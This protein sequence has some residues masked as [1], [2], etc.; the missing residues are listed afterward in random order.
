MNENKWNNHSTTSRFGAFVVNAA[1]LHRKASHFSVI[2]ALFLFV[3]SAFSHAGEKIVSTF[4]V[5]A[6]TAERYNT[7]VSADL[8]GSSFSLDENRLKLYEIRGQ[9][10]LATPCQLDNGYIPRLWWILSGLTK[11]GETRT[12]Q[13]VL[14]DSSE[15]RSDVL[16]ANDDEKL[17]VKLHGKNVLQYNQAVARPPEGV[18]S[19]YKRSGFIHPLWSPGGHVLTRIQPPD[20]RHHYGIWNPWTKTHY[21]GK[22][23]DFWNLGKGQGTVRFAGFLS[24]VSGPVYAEFRVRQEH[25][26]FM[27]LGEDKVALNEVWDVRVWNVG[28]KGHES[29][30]WDLTTTLNCADSPIDLVAYRY[31]GGIGFRAT[32]QWT[33]DNSR[34]LTSEGKT[35][36]EADGTRARWC[37]VSGTFPDSQ[38]SGILFMSYPGNREHPEPMRVWPMNAN[39]GR[40]DLFFEFCPI[41]LKSWHLDPGRDYVLKYRMLVYYGS[42]TKIEANRLWWD[43][44]HP[45]KVVVNEISK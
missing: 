10:R 28:D 43:F 14:N 20:H 19:L 13:L 21:E 38:R 23:I 5:S 37:D 12:F 39:K 36:A 26:D 40:G 11:K 33:K 15:I 4:V 45:P 1:K 25:V 3:S 42:I 16:C 31:G 17:V 32:E 34:V 6:G 44:A 2:L 7:P 27:A 30:L 9:E 8:S 24:R 18:S 29:W 35:R 41:R 22:E